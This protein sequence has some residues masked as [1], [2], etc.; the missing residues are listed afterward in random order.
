ML[1]SAWQAYFEAQASGA[2]GE[3]A[4]HEQ[5]DLNLQA[6]GGRTALEQEVFD[7]RTSKQ[8]TVQCQV[9]HKIG[10]GMVDC[11][12]GFRKLSDIERYA[13][14]YQM[15]WQPEANVYPM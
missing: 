13:K 8:R 5:V 9:C 7:L 3:V 6:S 1:R 11:P 14:A 10:H 15:K 12:K 4:F 2:D